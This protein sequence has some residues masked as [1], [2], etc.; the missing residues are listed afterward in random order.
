MKKGE[1]MFTS[2]HIKS[3]N[4]L[5]QS[6]HSVEKYIEDALAKGYK[7]VV[8]NE[9]QTLS[10]ALSFYRLAKQND[11][12]PIIAITFELDN[13]SLSVFANN[14]NGYF[15]LVDLSTQLLSDNHQ[16]DLLKYTNVTVLFNTISEQ[17]VNFAKYLREQTINP[18]YFVK[19]DISSDGKLYDDFEF[20]MVLSKP[21]HYLYPSDLSALKVLKA[22]HDNTTVNLETLEISGSDYLLSA[23]DYQKWCQQD[24][25]SYETTKQFIQS[26]TL[27]IPTEQNLL[28]NFSQNADELLREKAY[29]GLIDKK[30]NKEPYIQRLDKELKIIAQMGFSNYFLIVWDLMAYAHQQNI[31][32]GAGRGSSAAS[33][34][35]Y[36]LQITNVDPVKYN[37]LFERFLNPQRRTMP[38]IDLDFP[39]NRR[40]EMLHYASQKYG[41]DKV[42]QIATFGTFAAKQALR[43]VARVLGA[44]S[45]ELKM[46]S[47]AIGHVNSLK[48]APKALVELAGKTIRHQAILRIAK[49]IEGLPRHLSTHA[50]GVVISD[51][52]L[53]TLIPVQ[54]KENQLLLTQFDM[55]DVQAVGLLKMDFLGLRNLSILA[56]AVSFVQQTN[57]D[58]D[59]WKID[60][61]DNKTLELFA[62]GQT[63]GVFQFESPGIKRVLRQV[64]PNSLEEVAIVNALY[65]P[66]PMEQIGVYVKR[67]FEKE[68][69]TYLHEDLEPILKDT[70]GI[71]VYQ[72]QVML[73][74]NRMAGYSIGQADLLR[75]A[76]AKMDKYI[77]AN[78]KNNFINGAVNRG[79]SSHVAQQVFSYIEKF[80]NYGFPKSHAFA[81]SVLAFQLAYLKANFPHAFYLALLLHTNPKSSRYVLYM[82][83]AHQYGI[84]FKL[85]D[86]NSSRYLH[87]IIDEKTILLG[88]SAIQGLRYEVL[89]TVLSERRQNGPFKSLENFIHR[90]DD[91]S[92]KLDNIEPL[93][94]SGCFDNFKET[95]ASLIQQVPLILNDRD[96]FGGG[97]LPLK[98]VIV[99]E[100]TTDEI[101]NYEKQYL[102][103]SINQ[104]MNDT[105]NK[106]YY[107][108]LLTRTIDVTENDTVSLMGT[109]KSVRKITTKNN[110]RMAFST[111]EDTFGTLNI[112]IFPEVYQRFLTILDS[113][114]VVYLIGKIQKDNHDDLVCIVSYLQ[115]K[116]EA[117]V[118]LT[119]QMKHL[120]IKVESKKQLDAVYTT[121]KD[122]TGHTPVSVYIEN[123]KVYC[124]LD[125]KYAVRLNQTLLLDLELKWGKENVV[126]RENIS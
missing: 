50:A 57:K 4:S 22:I 71:I 92:A 14:E 29:E 104:A 31:M 41:E 46:W 16:V 70:Q 117:S 74:A 83:Q 53:N 85:P 102:G 23:A 75:R 112:T 3:A 52:A 5:L 94:Y 72:E 116:E 39:D 12:V 10:S 20:P 89:S 101:I 62:K 47:S 82:T 77:M 30:L 66:G 80:A 123:E 126:I 44:T 9:F 103:F 26:I 105:E 21:V 121:L 99:P 93:I 108:G 2:L 73:I 87:Q 113:G 68:P 18:I 98:K 48:K 81:Y 76:I 59:I 27:S 25:V 86:I 35:S 17:T 65:R 1:F 91:K 45:Q 95:R 24:I 107:S 34:V 55:T 37:L 69:V 125:K 96:F 56:D 38:D 32:T 19:N 49:Q 36:C 106:W 43:D 7:Y 40:Q 64:K 111:L 122:H 110:K 67:K 90:L 15:E 11:L 8:L 97:L 124:K 120:Y 63:D 60:F 28:P 78:E 115:L 84:T 42:A 58:F 54:K 88:L 100:F 6:P 109:L 61:N 119:E 51:T 118:Q 114:N 13:M 79:Y 33:L